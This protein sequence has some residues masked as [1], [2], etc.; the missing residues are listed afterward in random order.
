MEGVDLSDLEMYTTF[1]S[2]NAV[3]K[4]SSSL[5][6]TREDFTSYTHAEIDSDKLAT[7]QSNACKL[8]KEHINKEKQRFAIN[9]TSCEGTA[10]CAQDH[11]SHWQ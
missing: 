5:G 1:L 6:L 4:C 8:S 10:S 2:S 9:K 7:L 11:Y 3:S